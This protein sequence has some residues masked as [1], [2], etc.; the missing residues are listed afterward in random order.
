MY[1]ERVTMKEARKIPDKRESEV[2]REEFRGKEE[3]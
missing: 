3:T 1:T 2:L